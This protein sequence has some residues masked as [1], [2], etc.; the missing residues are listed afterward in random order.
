[1]NESEV[2]RVEDSKGNVR[3][4]VLELLLFERRPLRDDIRAIHHRSRAAGDVSDPG[5]VEVEDLTSSEYLTA[6]R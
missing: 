1:M 4:S 2:M 3:I 5:E 6:E